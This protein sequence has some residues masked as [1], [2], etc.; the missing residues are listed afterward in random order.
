MLI[1]S[2]GFFSLFF[3]KR[4]DGLDCGAEAAKFI[5][6]AVEEGT[7]DFRFKII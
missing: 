6:R 7:L 4:Q 1:L 3:E 5:S 2:V